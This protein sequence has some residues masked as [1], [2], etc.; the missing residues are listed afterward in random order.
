M[1]LEK[2]RE[3]ELLDVAEGLLDIVL[4]AEK[5]AATNG[6]E[7]GVFGG[8]SLNVA[9]EEVAGEDFQRFSSSP[10]SVR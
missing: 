1:E 8:A 2:A 5:S 4:E 3:E 7:L 6:F 10:L 9:Q